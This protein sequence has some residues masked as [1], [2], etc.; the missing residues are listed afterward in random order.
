MEV[1]RRREGLTKRKER[2]KRD[3]EEG[4]TLHGRRERERER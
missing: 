3:R 1:N 4:P 2:E